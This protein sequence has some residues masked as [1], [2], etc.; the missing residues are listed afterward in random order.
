MYLNFGK[1][2]DKNHPAS[3]KWERALPTDKL[4]VAVRV[5]ATLSLQ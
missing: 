3:L 1:S 4:D 5:D 2:E